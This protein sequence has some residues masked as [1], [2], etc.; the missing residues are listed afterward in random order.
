M[1][2]PRRRLCVVTFLAAALG[3]AALTG[4]A[5]APGAAE[6]SV[7]PMASAPL[8]VSKPVSRILFGSCLNQDKDQ[9]IWNAVR[10]ADGDLFLFIGDNIY[11]DE[12]TESGERLTGPARIADAYNALAA[13]APFSALRA[14]TPV[15]AT[16]DDHDYGFNDAGAE[17]I[18]RAESQRLFL[19][20]WAAAADDPRR[21][22]DG[23]YEAFILGPEGRRV[24]IILLDTRSF[25]S[26]WR[27]TDERDAP[28][29]ERYVP[30]A[31]ASKTILGPAQWAWLAAELRK[32]ADVRLVIS[33]YQV[34]A[35]GHG[36]ER[37]GLL[38]LERERLYD[39]IAETG[40]DGVVLLSGDRHLGAIYRDPDAPAYPLYE[41]TSSSLN[42]PS[43]K[44]LGGYVEPGPKRIADI[45]PEA[46]FG[47][48]EIDWEARGVALELRGGDGALLRGLMIPLEEV[49]ASAA[50]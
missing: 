21:S 27:A 26:P 38:P 35:E 39:L 19:D 2:R 14:Q 13:S 37:W 15:R 12:L 10:A 8:D 16:W 3:A 30:D 18:H 1:P 43:T 20:A 17:F 34:I 32:P 23:I 5:A 9:S 50:R 24:Q 7:T 46:N 49:S 29:K 40:A 4:A 11:A 45:A 48:V 47:V 33:S 22:R 6:I 31:D 28:G 42:L 44:W 25:R 36:Y 41:I